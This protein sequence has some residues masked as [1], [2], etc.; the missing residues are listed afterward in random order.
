MPL[1]WIFEDGHDQYARWRA[2]Q[3]AQVATR[4]AVSSQGCR[5]N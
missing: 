5:W 3:S 4:A 1:L 2:N